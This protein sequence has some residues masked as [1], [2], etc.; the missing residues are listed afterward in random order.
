MVSYYQIKVNSLV[1]SLVIH[2]AKKQFFFAKSLVFALAGRKLKSATSYN[3][4]YLASA[5]YKSL[6]AN[7][8]YRSHFRYTHALSEVVKDIFLRE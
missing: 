6:R 8:R 3:T 4:E 5:F 7:A 1:I 2:D